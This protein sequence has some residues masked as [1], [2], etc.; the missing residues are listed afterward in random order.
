MDCLHCGDCC[1]RM[2]PL[3]DGSEPCPHIVEVDDFVFCCIYGKRPQQCVDHDFP[4]RFCPIGM[5]ILKLKAADEVAARID[6]GWR[7]ISEKTS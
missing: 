3:N 4:S 5:S 1:K 6:N 2:C 7:L